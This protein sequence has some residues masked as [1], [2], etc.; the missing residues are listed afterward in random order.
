MVYKIYWPEIQRRKEKIMANTILVTGSTGKVGSQVV[1]QLAA[2]GINV[3]AAVQATSKINAIKR[4]GAE[5]AVIDFKRPGTFQ[6]ALRGVERIFMVTPFVPNMVE[7]AANLVEEIK[8]AGIKQIVRLSAMGA[9]AEPAITLGRW[10]REAEKVIEASGIDYTFLRPNMFMQN[11]LSMPT[12]KAQGAFYMPTGDGKA[13]YVD[14]RDIAAVA[15]AALTKS[16]HEG[17]AYEVTGPA[18]LDNY[19]VAEILSKVT[20][21]KIDYVSVSDDDARKGMRNAD[22]PEWAI[23]VLLE[24]YGIQRAG[25]T[26]HISPAVE[27]VTGK[28]P[29]AFEQFAKDYVEDFVK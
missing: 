29:I 2:D 1:Q 10:H 21:K 14:T 20:G 12:I 4:V 23:D 7:I 26:S 18:A 3:R 27:Q 11:Y 19:Q 24:L 28:K 25:Y 16:G 6:P 22:I 13:S 15:V 8:K 17:K 9:D 5:P